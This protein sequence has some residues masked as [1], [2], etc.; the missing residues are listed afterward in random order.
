M[1]FAPSAAQEALTRHKR[2]AMRSI[3]KVESS[4]SSGHSLH[5]QVRLLELAQTKLKDYIS[6]LEETL[7]DQAEELVTS[8]YHLSLSMRSELELKEQISMLEAELKTLGL[9]TEL[10]KSQQVQI[11][12]SE[13]SKLEAQR[14]ASQAWF[15]AKNKVR[16]PER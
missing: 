3:S 15:C 12:R 2:S 8:E 16:A 10:K 11:W 4:Q 6:T 1:L 7:E 14:A 5:E 13:T 9:E